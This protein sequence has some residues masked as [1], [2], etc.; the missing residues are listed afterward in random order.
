MAHFGVAFF[1]TDYSIQP[2]PLARALEERNLDSL[3]VTEHTHIPASR[4]TPWPGGADLP[5]EYWHTHD[6]FV[7]LAAAAAVTERLRLGTGICLVVERDP[8][9]LAKEVASLDVISD[10]RVILGVG[11]GWN[12]EEM[13]NHGVR[14]DKRWAIVREKVL[15]MQ[16]IWTEDEPEFHGEFVDFDKLWSW[17]K[18]VQPGGPKVLVG[19]QSRFTWNRVAE[20]GDGWMPIGIRGGIEDGMESV[21]AACEKS[22]RDFESLSHTIFAPQ[23]KLSHCENLIKLGFDDLAFSLPSVPEDEAL[24]MLDQFAELAEQLR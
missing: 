14:F 13:E 3:Y 22:G 20:W 24:P 5:K 18:P 21:K 8:I 10:G 6:P 23:P 16:A 12:Q 11:A 7:A 17:P 15:A 2:I 9:Q 1:P 4:K 19:A